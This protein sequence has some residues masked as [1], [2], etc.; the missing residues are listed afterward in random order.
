MVLKK[1][2]VLKRERVNKVLESIF[3]FPLTI[4]EA[5][6]GYGK[7]TAVREFLTA[8]K[9]TALWISFSSPE[10]TNVSFWEEF[11]K[12]ISRINE[13]TGAKLKRLGFPADAPQ[14]SNVLSILSDID[15]TENTV[16]VIDDFHFV[17]DM[18][19]SRFLVR[20]I[21]EKL[22]NLHIVVVTRDTT[23][24]DFAELTAKGLCN[25][26]SQQQLRFTDEEIREY[27]LAMGCM[28]GKSNFKKISEYTGGWIS[29]IY[30]ILLGMEKG[31]PV[32]HN[33]AIDELIEKVVYNTYDE[34]IRQFLLKLSIMD[35]FTKEQAF[36]V[37][38]EVKTD[39]FLTKLRRENAFVAF[40]EAAGVYKIHN[41]LLDFLRSKHADETKRAALYR[42]VGEWYLARKAYVQACT[43]LSRGGETER[44]LVLLDEKGT[45][46]NSLAEFEGSFAMFAGAKREL[47]FRYPFAYLQ[48]IGLMLLSANAESVKDGVMRLD[49][50]KTFYEKREDLPQDLKNSIMAEVN[51]VRIFNVFNNAQKMLD[52][53]REAS[54]LL[55]GG[56]SRLFQ[57]ESE[58]TFGCPHFLYSYYQEPGRLRQTVDVMVKGFP[59]FTRL[60]DGC[61]AG[62]DYVTLAEY[63]LET[64][65]WKESELNAFKAIYKAQTKEQTGIVICA[66]L[67]LIRLYIY[68]GK[69]TEALELLRQLRK[70]VEKENNPV[71]N[72]TLELVDGYVYGCL[73]RIDR[74][75][76]WLQTGD[77]SPAHFFYEGLGFNYIVY[78]KAV[79]LSKNYIQLEMLTESFTRCFSI[80]HNQLGFLH[81]QILDAAAKYWLYGMEAGCASMRKA[82][83]MARVDNIILTFAE[84]A[85]AII[86]VLRN[87]A[88]ADMHDAYTKE[89]LKA[90]EHYMESLKCVGQNAVSLS[91]RE[92]EVLSLAAEG[93]KRD[94]IAGRLG[95]STGTV[96]THLQNIY[97]KLEV[98]SRT[99]A[100]K[101]AKKMKL[102]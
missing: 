66:N 6:I 58:F 93:L 69:I 48:Y 20:I 14:V 37:T 17:K 63:A 12:S 57:K 91:A 31:I 29:L 92:L 80:L 2:K 90:C 100:I 25:I 68:E 89:V 54:R 45:L 83:D 101:K 46:S 7:T 27:C 79:L 39:E 4:V 61:G 47:L 34:R 76:Q 59:D 19:I 22:E 51:T 43:Y 96:R 28:P 16:M 65:D 77:M 3:Y 64:G 86:D 84:Y 1:P 13:A 30:L 71:Y 55:E 102:F 99:A 9:Y 78:G 52:C 8:P 56:F 95:V 82:L 23:N 85:P 10:D 36:F 26:I 81:N 50:L 94:E 74:I 49:E 44:V 18:Q 88:H 42:R 21:R 70:D 67:T 5:P 87:I 32:G 60:T 53:T 33:N 24:L 62:C 97:Q 73:T 40:D 11:S 41:V 72:T 75:P 15:Y 35:N 38:E 98:G